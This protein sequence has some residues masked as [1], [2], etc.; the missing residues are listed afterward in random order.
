MRSRLRY[1]A[2]LLATLAT[3][4][5]YNGLVEKDQGT[6]QAWAE[7]ENQLQ[8]R[9]DLVP[10]LVE[11]VKGYAGHESK[12]FAEIAQARSAMLASGNGPTPA[13]MAAA[14]Q[15]EQ[16][17][18]KLISI[19]EAYPTLK[20]DANFARLMD[21]LAGTENRLAVARKRYNDAVGDYNIAVRSFPTVMTARMFGFAPNKDYFKAP[22]AAKTPPQVHFNS[23][24]GQ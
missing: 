15:F 7:V 18:G 10:N 1:T 22:E 20:A 23:S 24:T 5:G 21:E 16:T 19:S 8:R 3:G 9:T 14:N 4:C 6:A 11:T 17:I 12:I 2:L 13:R